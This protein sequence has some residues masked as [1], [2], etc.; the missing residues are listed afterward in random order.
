MNKRFLFVNLSIE[1]GFNTG[2]NHGIAFL[3]PLLR[4]RSYEVACLNIRSVIRVEDFRNK[5]KEFNPSIVGFSCTSHQLKYLTKYSKAIEGFGNIL[6]IAGG[7][8]PTLEPEWILSRSAVNGVCIGEGEIPLD[9]LLNNIENK[10]DI[11]TTQGFYWNVNADIKKNLI[12]QFVPDLSD[13]DFPDYSVF[14]RSLVTNNKSLYIMLSRGCPYNCNYCCNG[15]KRG[16]YSSSKGYFRIPSVEYSI[17]LIEKVIVHYPETEYIGFEDDLLIANKTWFESFAREYRE[18]IKIPY[19]MCV[20][21]ECITPDIARA[22]KKSGCSRASV[23]LESGNDRLRSELLN[24]KHSNNLL[25]E[26]CQIIKDAGIDLFTFNIVGFPFETKEQMGQ[27]LELNKKIDPN[28]GLCTFFYPYRGT[29]LYR[30]CQENNL[31]KT[32]DEMIEITN[33][34]TK[35]SVKMTAAGERDCIY[36]QRKISNY[37][38]QQKELTEISRLPGLIRK[39]LFVIYRLVGPMLRA[40]PLLHKIGRR[41]FRLLGVRTLVMRSMKNKTK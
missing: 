28:E 24:R 20:R 19:R 2:I 21:V 39:P 34:N 12:P 13:I 35:P 11:F 7:V 26:K 5:I 29:E 25:M 6:Q 41:F 27:T 8:A 31:L 15:A 4:K 22:L 16:V 32:D 37:L 9:D 40:V 30:I 33:Y 23:G 18:R 38:W 1:C 17:G 3:V 10:R 36:F 14:D